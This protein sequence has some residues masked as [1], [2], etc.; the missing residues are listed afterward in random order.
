MEKDTAEILEMLNFIKDRM[1]TKDD[2]DQ[3]FDAVDVRL[4]K[5]EARLTNIETELRDI[6]KR[7][8]VLEVAAHN[9]SGFSKEIDHLLERVVAIE[10]HIGLR[11]H[12]AA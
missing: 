10:K 7:I 11:Q 2:I 3:R 6:R 5:V 12:A 9:S 1:A 4:D 8:E